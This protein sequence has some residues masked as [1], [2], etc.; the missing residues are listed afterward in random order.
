MRSPARR[1]PPPRGSRCRHTQSHAPRPDAGACAAER[2]GAPC[3]RARC[4]GTHF[5]QSAAKHSAGM[6]DQWAHELATAMMLR[7]VTTTTTT[8]TT[9]PHASNAPPAAAEYR[10]PDSARRPRPHS[11]GPAYNAGPWIPPSCGSPQ[12]QGQQQGGRPQSAHVARRAGPPPFSGRPTPVPSPRAR[13]HSARSAASA[14]SAASGGGGGGR[15]KGGGPRPPPPPHAAPPALV[16]EASAPTATKI[17]PAAAY[18]HA[19]PPSAAAALHA[20]TTK[21]MVLMARGHPDAIRLMKGAGVPTGSWPGSEPPPPPSFHPAWRDAPRLRLR[22]TAAEAA[23]GGAL[24]GEESPRPAGTTTPRPAAWYA[25]RPPRTAGAVP[26]GEQQGSTSPRIAR[27]G[28][29]AAAPPPAAPWRVP[30]RIHRVH[31]AHTSRQAVRRAQDPTTA[32]GNG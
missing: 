10:P 9:T 12:Q 19:P 7:P 16:V 26:P 8:T 5:Y 23:P 6:A 32:F 24:G 29:S 13:P 25:R 17:V 3:A 21:T 22:T 2:C 28:S 1:P 11:A 20:T 27:A 15:A 30:P 31:L 4:T 18:R 14:A